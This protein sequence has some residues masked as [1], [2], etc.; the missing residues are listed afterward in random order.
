[1]TQ[2]PWTSTVLAKVGRWSYATVREFQL[3]R[4]RND[5]MSETEADGASSPQSC[6]AFGCV[7]PTKEGHLR[8][9]KLTTD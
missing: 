9:N 6:V 8:A 2:T 3:I 5:L 7:V 4:S 1:M